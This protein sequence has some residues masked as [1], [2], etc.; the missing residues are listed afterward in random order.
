MADFG[1]AAFD[2]ASKNNNQIGVLQNF[3]YDEKRSV[4]LSVYF[5]KAK[6]RKTDGGYISFDGGIVNVPD[7][8]TCEVMLDLFD[9]KLH[10]LPRAIHRGAIHIAT[11]VA[12]NGKIVSVTQ[13]NNF[14][15]PKSRIEKTK[16]KLARANQKV[17]IALIGDSLT[18]GAG[19]N[20][21]W[22]FLL[23]STANVSSGFNLSRLT[24]VQVDNYAVGSQTSRYEAAVVLGKSAG[25]NNSQSNN[26]SIT[27]GEYT[28]T[29]YFSSPKISGVSPLL[30]GQY[31]LAIVSLGANGGSNMLAFTENI[32]KELRLL[33]T[34]VI[35]TSSNFGRDTPTSLYDE[36]ATMSTMADVW[37]CEFADTWSYVKE[38]SWN[39]QTVHVDSIH[40][41]A[42]GHLAWAEGIRSVLNDIKQEP[43][44]VELSNQSRIITELDS[45]ISSKF[46]NAV[47]IVFNPFA[48]TGTTNSGAVTTTT[49]NPAILF[50]GKDSSNYI[51]N[52]E[53][54]QYVDFAHAHAHAV[55]ILFD[56]S[57]AFTADIL[58]QGG[59][60]VIKSIAFAG[61]H[62]SRIGLIEGV[63]IGTY[64]DASVGKPGY[65][66]GGLRIKC[67]SGTMKVVGVVFH[68]WKSKEIPFKDIEFI[69]SWNEEAWTYS[70]PIS[71]YTDTDTD[72]FTFDFVGTGAQLLFSNRDASGKIDVYLDGV[73][74]YNQ[75]DLYIG[76][77]TYNKSVD[78]FPFA[79]VDQFDRGYGKHTVKVVFNGVNASA[80]AST[81]ANRRV[82]LLAAYAFDAR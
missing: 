65:R 59:A 23:F 35:V 71:K 39:G 48:R 80:V 77:G 82:Q 16:R 76:A 8:L 81:T 57:T 20:P 26:T 45:A 51:Q 12:T 30:T 68:K 46:P 43:E 40:M 18:Q 6:L 21:Y 13:P 79:S 34:E 61:V 5:G 54:G 78:I 47:D 7:N 37:G 55:D 74:I 32:V 38:A 15:V 31:D 14:S 1:K 56:Y 22:R 24:D 28:G 72:W 67:T 66:N 11:V 10:A 41:S 53:V 49:F 36:T 62:P 19:E 69:G 25:S 50:G 52:L 73:K 33:G 60:T 64:G 44:R 29:R 27:Y 75:L 70:H 63:N 4:G 3:I 58:N 42:L 9:N 17:K 2:L